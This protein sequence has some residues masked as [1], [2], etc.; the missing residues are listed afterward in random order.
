LSPLA[1][2]VSTFLTNVRIRDFRA[3]FRA[4]LVSVWRMRF[5]ADSVLAMRSSITS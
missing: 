4:V 2:A 5:R 3:L 1:M